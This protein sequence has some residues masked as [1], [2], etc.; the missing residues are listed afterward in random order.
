MTDQTSTFFAPLTGRGFIIAKGK[1]ATPFLQTILTANIDR[2]AVG[3]CAPGALL[4]P[5]GRILHD[6]MIYH[7]GAT[8]TA[9][10]HFIIEVED[11]KVEIPGSATEDDFLEA[12][13][14]NPIPCHGT[15]KKSVGRTK[16]KHYTS[17]S[18]AS[19]T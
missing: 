8:S 5:Q 7:V 6:M 17:R 15:N 10:S 11:R 16:S 18:I 14:K 19:N 4:T 1:E 13:K 9:G 2:I 3:N 12:F